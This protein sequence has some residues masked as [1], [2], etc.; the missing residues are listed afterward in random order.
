MKVL[1]EKQTGKNIKQLMK[2]RNITV[3]NLSATLSI[4]AQAIYRWIEGRKMPTIDNLV[5]LADVLDVSVDE[6]IARREIA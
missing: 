5:I 2:A 3:I 1:D 6:I 4:S